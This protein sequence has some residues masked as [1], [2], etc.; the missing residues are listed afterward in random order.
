MSVYFRNV[1]TPPTGGYFFETHGE[2]VSAKYY[3]DMVA[4]VRA[5]MQKYKIPGDVESVIASYMCP[6]IPE[7]GWLCTGDFVPKTIL[8]REALEASLRY[9]TRHVT[10][11]DRI[12]QRL[13][14]C[15]NCPNHTRD[16]CVTCTGHMGQIMNRFGQA[17]PAL[18]EDRGS[19]I[20]KCAKAYEVAIASV[21]FNPEE[22]V[23]PDTPDTCWRKTECTKA[24]T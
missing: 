24:T 11:F 8:P 22:Q 3:C 7:A 15:M 12:Q 9:T 21:E 14:T 20:C 4:P 1:N 17:R 10:T 19:G 18:P 2:Q 13:R 6:R 5:L 16:F 23:W